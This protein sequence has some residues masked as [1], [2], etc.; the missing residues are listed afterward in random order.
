[1]ASLDHI[2]VLMME[3]SSFD[4]MLGALFPESADGGGI[5]GTAANH[6]N[7]DS[8]PTPQPPT[9]HVM[10]PTTTRVVQ[11][12]PS[13]E[14]TNVL[15][16][17]AGPNKGYITDFGSVYPNTTWLQRQEIM[18][19]YDDGV[20]ANLHT[21]AK[22]YTVCDRWFSSMPGPTW[23]NRIFVHTG[24]SL[25]YTTNSVGNNW[26]QTTLYELLDNNGISWK[27]YLR[28]R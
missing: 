27:I 8:S 10:Q 11:P 25:G 23:P 7:D 24:T 12:D 6:W 28:R 9:R 17:I 26:D 19:Y 20:L 16:Q 14:H 2:I 13:H 18:N 4:R 15:K 1:M 22:Q 3:N 5:K 21:L